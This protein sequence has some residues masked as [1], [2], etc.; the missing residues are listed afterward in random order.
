VGISLG[1]GLGTVALLTTACPWLP[2]T[3]DALGITGVWND[4]SPYYVASFFTAAAGAVTATALVK[5]E[6]P[7]WKILALV[8]C[9]LSAL[10]AIGSLALSAVIS[11]GMM[12]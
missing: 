7:I 3:R 9:V 2:V 5:R 1:L 12:S 6:L 10:A 8:L 11:F 4:P